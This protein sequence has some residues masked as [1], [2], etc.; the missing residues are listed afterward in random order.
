MDD[1]IADVVIPARNEQ[2]TIRDIVDIFSS[3]PSIG[4]VIVGIDADTTDST[5]GLLFRT[6]AQMVFGERG[7]GQIV[8][9]C[10]KA[11]ETPYVLFCDADI[12]G[13]TTDHVG[14][15]VA[16]ATVD[17]AWDL[18]DPVMTVGVPEIPANLPTDRLWAWPWVSGQR[19]VPTR[20]VRPLRLHGYLMETQINAAAR[21]ASMP[22]RFEWLRG[23]KSEY[24]MTER[25]LDEMQRDAVWGREHGVL[26]WLSRKV[27]LH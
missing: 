10:L 11:V 18:G 13:L 9:K 2:D 16:E 19:C 23:V 7:K 25:R 21:H 12:T 17:S 27:P 14:L 22:V 24:K 26:L 6:T 3:H 15:L 1:Y 5:I 20:L 8:T 4:N